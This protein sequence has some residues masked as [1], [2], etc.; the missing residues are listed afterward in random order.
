MASSTPPLL[1][2][3]R[4]TA[5]LSAN[6]SPSLPS[7]LIT[8]P[9][10]KLLAH[11]SPHPVSV[12]RTHATVA[13]SLLSIHA[14]NLSLEESSEEEDEED[15]EEVSAKE[16]TKPQTVTVQT[17]TGVVLI[18]RLNC[19]LLFVCI[20]IPTESSSSSS[21]AEDATVQAQLDPGEASTSLTVPPPTVSTSPSDAGSH[22]SSTVGTSASVA[23]AVIRRH[24]I[25]LAKWLD[26]KLGTL[27]VPDEGVGGE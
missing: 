11:A 9:T 6:T 16:V 24:A 8:S 19:G 27:T 14:S 2:T 13:A 3:K 23:D 22:L 21:S 17:D 18:R 20:G 25:E 1:L 15:A 26:D 7:L 10:G 12:L 4:L 5:F